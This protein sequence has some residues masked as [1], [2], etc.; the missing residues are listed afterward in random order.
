M[1]VVVVVGTDLILWS[2]IEGQLRPGGH[3]VRR[4]PPGAPLPDPD[5]AQLAI[6]D[7]E[8]VD[9]A[10]AVAALR[11]ARLLGFGSH[12]SPEALK[13][14]RQAGFDRVVA[15]SAVAE[16]LTSLVDELLA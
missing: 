1:A 15:R 10:E 4:V 14:A 16:R 8:G 5:G 12:L 3:E 9:P 2:R 11:P 7:V 13:R 6:C